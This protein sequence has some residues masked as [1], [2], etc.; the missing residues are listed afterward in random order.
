MQTFSNIFADKKK[1]RNKFIV[2][3]FIYSERNKLD[4]LDKLINNIDITVYISTSNKVF[5]ECLHKH[6]V[7]IKKNIKKFTNN[8]F[9]S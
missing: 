9:I 3:E 4:K 1:L 7:K 5:L 2:C 8:S 6:Q